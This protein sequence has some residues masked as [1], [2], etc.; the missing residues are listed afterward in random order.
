MWGV[1][2]IDP[3]TGRAIHSRIGTYTL[4]GSEYMEASMFSG[5]STAHLLGKTFRFKMILEGDTLTQ[6]GIDNPYTT[7]F[8]RIIKTPL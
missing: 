5:Q 1:F 2:Q 6:I 3:N 8:K 7:S 4:N